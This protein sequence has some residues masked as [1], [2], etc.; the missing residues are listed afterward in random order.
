ME[1]LR[2]V[3]SQLDGAPHRPSSSALCP[4]PSPGLAA[5]FWKSL[6]GPC[7]LEQCFCWR[8]NSRLAVILSSLKIAFY[9]FLVLAFSVEK[10]DVSLSLF[11]EYVFF[12]LATFSSFTMKCLSLVFLVFA[13]GFSHFSDPWFD[14]FHQFWK[15]LSLATYTLVLLPWHPFC[16]A[17]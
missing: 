13:W 4:W 17:K 2:A 1:L 16:L 12:P 15:T 8:Q 9:C 5:F 11:L 6:Y 3:T 14:G 10:S 7:T